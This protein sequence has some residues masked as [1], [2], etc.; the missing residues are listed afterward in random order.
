MAIT[1]WKYHKMGQ[2]SCCSEAGARLYVPVLDGTKLEGSELVS[3]EHIPHFDAVCKKCTKLFSLDVICTVHRLPL[4]VHYGLCR[5][6]RPVTFGKH[7]PT[8]G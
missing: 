7:V 4:V 2:C 8:S 5:L 1:G 6:C 3:G